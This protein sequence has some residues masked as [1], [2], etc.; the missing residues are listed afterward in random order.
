MKIYL[1]LSIAIFAEVIA[2]SALKASE[3]F[4]QLVPSIIAVIGYIIAFYFMSLVIKVMPIGIT[5]AIWSG[6][7]IVLLA[8]IGVIVYGQRLDLAAIIGMGLIV[9]GVM[10][11][12]LFSDSI[13]H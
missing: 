6:A 8:I 4:T 7:G 10:V 11:I 2:T 9:L 3:T 12:H 1:F 13:T 5:Y